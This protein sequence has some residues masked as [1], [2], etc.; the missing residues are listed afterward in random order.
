MTWIETTQDLL[1]PSQ[2]I[3]SP[4]KTFAFVFYHLGKPR[5][6]DPL[7]AGGSAVDPPPPPALEATGHISISK[8]RESTLTL[9]RFPESLGRGWEFWQWSGK[10][11]KNNNNN[12]NNNNE[13][14]MNELLQGHLV[15]GRVGQSSSLLPVL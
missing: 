1:N 9:W 12:N 10:R 5:S 4:R 3:S 6:R 15:D 8:S 2:P 14:H 13:L 11:G 7:G